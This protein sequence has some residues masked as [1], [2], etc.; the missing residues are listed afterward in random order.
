M[1]KEI[2][3][4]INGYEGLYKISSYGRVKSFKLK[5]ER[6]LK[7]SKSFHDF[8]QVVLTKNKTEKSHKCHALVAS[9]FVNNNNNYRY[10]L[11]KDFDK[12]N[13]NKDNLIWSQ[14]KETTY[15]QKKQKNK[16]SKYKGVSWRKLNEKW[17]VA[18]TK[19]QSRIY[20]GCFKKESDAGLA[21][22]KA[23]KKLFGQ[24]ARLNK[25]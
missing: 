13:I 12:K 23:A 7:N 21:Y 25:I 19:D 18:I 3:K 24:F 5:N 20:L 6:I 9:H 1:E 10:I 14:H 15:T 17:Q 8:Y 4:D 22:N 11:H 2:W 16:S